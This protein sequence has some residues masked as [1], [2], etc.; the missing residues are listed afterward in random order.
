VPGA[1][2]SVGPI[3]LAG[4]WLKLEA[5][6]LAEN[7]LCDIVLYRGKRVAARPGDLVL[8][9]MAGTPVSATAVDAPADARGWRFRARMFASVVLNV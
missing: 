3:P 6:P 1:R 5:Q 9:D 7:G 8:K 4:G 2:L